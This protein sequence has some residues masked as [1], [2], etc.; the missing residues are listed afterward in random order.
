MNEGNGHSPEGDAQGIVVWIVLFAVASVVIG[1]C[2]KYLIDWATG[3]LVT[4]NSGKE[5]FGGMVVGVIGLTG[6]FVLFQ[7]LRVLYERWAKL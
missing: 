5:V 2:V 4:E 3:S 6:L 1:F 7:L